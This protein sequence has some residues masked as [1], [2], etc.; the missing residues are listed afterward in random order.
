MIS[1][2]EIR[3]FMNLILSRA[4]KPPIDVE[5]RGLREIGFESLDFAELALRVER[6]IGCEI[7]FEG[8]HLRAIVTAADALDFFER[9]GRRG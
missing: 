3:E 9:A 6:R 4:G 1:R 5:T 7:N 2:D 8:A